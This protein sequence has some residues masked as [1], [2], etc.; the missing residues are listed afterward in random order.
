MKTRIIHL[1]CLVLTGVVA[2]QVGLGAQTIAAERLAELDRLWQAGEI[3]KC[4]DQITRL[5][6]ESVNGVG[7]FATAPEAVKLLKDLVSKEFQGKISGE[8]MLNDLEA[9]S[10][11]V[12]GQKFSGSDEVME[13]ATTLALF[14]GKIRESKIEDYMPTLAV[15]NVAPPSGN[16]PGFSGINPAA[17][18]N[19]DQKA[20]YEKAIRENQEQAA[21]NERQ[22]KLQLLDGSLSQQVVQFLKKA[23][24]S[25]G[26]NES[27]VSKWM[28]RAKLTAAERAIVSGAGN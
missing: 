23:A 15:A 27:D 17:L 4:Q 25:E 9:L 28:I 16:G 19:S 6:N 8:G 3:A 13:A 10:L 21:K 22:A 12:M 1:L 5:K 14:V 11:Y 7:A 20:A 18:T 2:P 26:V 24:E